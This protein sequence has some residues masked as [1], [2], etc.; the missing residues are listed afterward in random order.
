MQA[1]LLTEKITKMVEVEEIEETIHLSLSREEADIVHGIMGGLFIGG[2]PKRKVV[3]DIYSGLCRILGH[4][5][6]SFPN[7]SVNIENKMCRIG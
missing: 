6:Y 4:N 2:G 3:D 5:K 7:C 1:K